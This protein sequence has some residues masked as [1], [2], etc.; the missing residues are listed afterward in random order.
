MLFRSNINS[1][2]RYLIND[3]KKKRQKML[4]SSSPTHTIVASSSMLP[5]IESNEP[6][7]KRPNVLAYGHSCFYGALRNGAHRALDWLCTHYPN[8]YLRGRVV[9]TGRPVY[10]LHHTWI[11]LCKDQ[12]FIKRYSRQKKKKCLLCGTG[13]GVCVR[14]T[15]GEDDDGTTDG[16]GSSNNNDVTCMPCAVSMMSN[17]P[18]ASSPSSSTSKYELMTEYI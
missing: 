8:Y 1:S 16:N 13:D 12:N 11:P 5:P 10:R 2:Y 17:S 7:N 9:S 18:F 3:D 14:V 6:W 15:V 4:R